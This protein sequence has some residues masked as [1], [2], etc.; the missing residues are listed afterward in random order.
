MMQHVMVLRQ[1]MLQVPRTGII[2]R[3]IRRK[4]ARTGWIEV[5]LGSVS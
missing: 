5:D 2:K 4:K 3:L 1:R